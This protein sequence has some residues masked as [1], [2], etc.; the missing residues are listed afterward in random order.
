[1]RKSKDNVNS[2]LAAI[3]RK[4]PSAPSVREINPD[5][6]KVIKAETEITRKRPGK[7]EPDQ[8]KPKSRVGGPIQFWFHDEDRRLIRELAA[9]LAGQ[10]LRPT[11]SM[12]VRSALRMAKTGSA[13]LEAYHEEARLDGRLRRGDTVDT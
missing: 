5:P 2:L 10:G 12:V 8:A 7:P 11:D 13:L 3:Q 9:W 1:M 6:V 4:A